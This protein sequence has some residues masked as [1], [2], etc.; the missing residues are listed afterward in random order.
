MR[1]LSWDR[2]ER[3]LLIA[4][5]VLPTLFV[6]HWGVDQYVF[7]KRVLIAFLFSLLGMVLVGRSAWGEALRIELH[8]IN[9]LWVGWWLWTAVSWLWASSGSLAFERIVWLGII[10]GIVFLTQSHTIGRRDIWIRLAM[11]WAFA[12]AVLS[13]WVLRMDFWELVSP[14]TLAIRQRLGDWRDRASAAGLGNTGHIADFISL[15]FPATLMLFLHTR[16]RLSIALAGTTLGLMAAAL[17]VCWSVHSNA[18]LVLVLLI[19]LP[20]LVRMHPVSW[21]KRR[22]PRIMG[23]AAV[24]IAVIV[25][26]VL[27]HAANPHPGGIFREAFSSDRWQAGWPTRVA[28]WLTTLQM[29]RE[30]GIFGVG[31][32]NFTYAYPALESVPVKEAAHLAPYAHKWTN[33]A[34]NDLLQTWAETGVFGLILFAGLVGAVLFTLLRRYRD[35]TRGNRMILWPAALAAGAWLLQAQMN[36]PLQM[37]VGT[38]VF[39]LLSCVAVA[40]PVRYARRPPDI[41]VPVEWERGGVR[42]AVYLRNMDMRQPVRMAFETNWGMAGR[43]GM[44]LVLGVFVFTVGIIGW[45]G[46]AAQADFKAGRECTDLWLGGSWGSTRLAPV[47][48]LECAQP[49]F[50]KA[51]R[52]WPWLTDC[53]SAYTDLLVRAGQWEQALEQ[54]AL[55]RRRLDATEVYL[56]EALARAARGDT[57]AAV[58]AF[59][60]VLRRDPQGAAHYPE[61]IRMVMESEP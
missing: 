38:L 8:P 25:F 6:W 48:A 10:V 40:L 39:G 1:R 46:L 35:E 41:L 52:L 31:A 13:L 34:H 23:M 32:G 56:R 49:H 43:G 26:Y 12:A 22:A 29:I 50:E 57:A 44:L 42:M 19:G 11:A 16:R 27:P 59:L 4:L 17:I 61:L 30:H 2:L 21:W 58:D 20:A 28:I 33:A 51:L 15:A 54:G 47:K 5:V 53:H 55:V 3:A 14:G 9:G 24:W 36:F 60:E 45:R 37:P 18:A 7:P